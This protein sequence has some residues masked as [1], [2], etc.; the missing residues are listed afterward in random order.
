MNVDFFWP[1]KPAYIYVFIS[2][3][4]TS[5]AA[6]A[7]E[8]TS[9][10]YPSVRNIT[11]KD[12]VMLALDRNRSLRIADQR[13]QQAQ[14]NADAVTGKLMPHIDA[15]Y[16]S[17][18]SD[19]PINV[20][21]TKLLQKRFS[22]SDFAISNLNNPD[23]LNNY[24]TDVS[25]VVPVY[26]GGALWAG[27]RASEASA[28]SA[29][30]NY[31]AERQNTVLHVI[32]AFAQLKELQAERHA[33]GKALAAARD[34][35]AD[36]EA[37]KRRGLAIISDVMDAK[38]HM[39]EAGVTLDSVSHAVASAQDQLRLL[40]GLPTDAKVSTS[41]SI[42]LALSDQSRDAWL[43]SAVRHHP[44]LH[45]EKQRLDTARARADVAEAPFLPAINLHATEEWNSNTVT[46]KN[47]NFTIDAEVRFNLFSG[48]S[49]KARLHA[50]RAATVARELELED[51]RQAIHNRVLAAWRSLQEAKNR[52]TASKQVLRQ[53]L[54]SL[55]IRK[56]REQQGLEKSS[57]VLDAQ[58]RA[59]QARAKAI[60][61]RYAL[62]IAKAQLL[63]E[64][65]QLNP[66]VIR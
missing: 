32:Q 38:S 55:R 56:L 65:G 26:Q 30:W 21:G 50:A 61:A 27:K 10:A 47:A 16:A 44:V 11:M 14:D 31:I 18:R 25:I 6:Q 17:S 42:Q 23:A 5:P 24:H 58:S 51:I 57:D 62:V 41:G 52:L 46:P 64:A 22:A 19:S 40:L 3:L 45:V 12:A 15:V 9:P 49:D 2:I 29:R 37:L 1:K 13:R 28:K 59:D 35:L 4:M 48:G 63:A 60:H 7:G 53:S 36:T 33:A 54:E 20:F 39:L 8:H 34:H 43:K 66:E